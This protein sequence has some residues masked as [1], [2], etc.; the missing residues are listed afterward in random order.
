M[1]LIAVA[2]WGF[3]W[4]LPGVFLAV[5]LLIVQRQLFAG[6]ERTHFLAVIL[7]E[8]DCRPGDECEP[9]KEDQTIAEIA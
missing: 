5:P 4:G 8:D 1:V 6:F 9:I 3:I 2:F 7:G